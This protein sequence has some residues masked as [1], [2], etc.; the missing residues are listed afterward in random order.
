VNEW[1]VLLCFF[2]VRFSKHLPANSIVIFDFSGSIHKNLPFLATNVRKRKLAAKAK[3][4]GRRG[5]KPGTTIKTTAPRI[6]V[7]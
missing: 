1:S 6:E 7:S 2:L 3:K 5:R 4:P